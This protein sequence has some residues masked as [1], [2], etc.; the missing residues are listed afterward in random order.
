MVE[1]LNKVTTWII[2]VG[3][4]ACIAWGANKVADWMDCFFTDTL[5][6]SPPSDISNSL[7]FV[8]V[9]FWVVYVVNTRADKLER[10]IKSLREDLLYRGSSD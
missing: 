6:F 10:E 3:V 2:V 1:S 8:G 5:G 7:L 9:L 4:M